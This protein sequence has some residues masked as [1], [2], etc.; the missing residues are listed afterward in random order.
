MNPAQLTYNKEWFEKRRKKYPHA[1]IVP[2]ST[3]PKPH[4]LPMY[5]GNFVSAPQTDVVLWA[6]QTTQGRSLFKRVY[7]G[8]EA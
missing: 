8:E 3:S 5:F 7:G 1:L 4:T 2:R 6:F